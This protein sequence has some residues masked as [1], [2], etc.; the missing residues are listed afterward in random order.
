MVWVDKLVQLV[1]VVELVLVDHI[2]ELVCWV[3]VEVE[4]EVWVV[5]EVEAWVV[6]EVE[7][8]VVAGVLLE[9]H[10]AASIPVT[11]ELDGRVLVEDVGAAEVLE[12]VVHSWET[13]PKV[14]LVADSLAVVV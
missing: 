6:A 11:V 7:V 9:A 3:V 14:V 10:L 5:A 13:V 8:W 12:L 2:P 1:L 4:V